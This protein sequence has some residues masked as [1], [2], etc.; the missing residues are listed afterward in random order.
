MATAKV[1]KR[2]TPRNIRLDLTE[3]EADFLLGIT[4]ACISGDPVN[5]PRKYAK[6]IAKALTKATGYNYAETDSYPLA[7]GLVDF[8]DYG[9]APKT[10]GVMLKDTWRALRAF[11]NR[12]QEVEEV[13]FLL[14][15]TKMLGQ[16]DTPVNSGEL[17]TVANPLG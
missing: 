6:R 7:R 5:S 8:M 1:R 10:V 17:R 15:V 14:E 12:K 16:E 11:P 4:A 13:E 2:N 9:T 3:G